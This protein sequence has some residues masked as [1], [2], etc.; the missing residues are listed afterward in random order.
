MDHQDNISIPETNLSWNLYGAG[1]DNL[2][3]LGKPEIAPVAQPDS[4]QLLVRVDCVGICYSD[5]KLLQQGENHPKIKSR[6]L[7]DCP[8]SPGHEV[9]FTVILVGDSL[10]DKFRAG[11]RYVVQPEIV[12]HNKK[13]TYGFSFPGGLTQYQ[14]IGSELLSTDDGVSILKIDDSLG[15]AEACLLEPWGSVLST[16][17]NTRRLEPKPGGNMWIIG[18]PDIEIERD[19]SKYLDHPEFILISDLPSRLE[20]S[21]LVANKNVHKQNGISVSQYK[22]IVEKQDPPL[23]FDDIVI[24]DPQSAEQIEI[25]ISMINPGGLINLI[26]NKPLDR[27]IKLDPQRIHYDFISIIGN[28]SSDLAESYGTD[29]NRSSLSPKGTA[30]FYGAG[31]AMGQIHVENAIAALDGPEKIVVIDINQERLD[32]LEQRFARLAQQQNKSLHTVNPLS[33]LKDLTEHI[34]ELI[35]QEY[36]NDVV[37]LVPDTAV[38]KKA[39]SLLGEDSLL[40]LFAG[41]PA[42]ASFPID[43]SNVYLGNLQITGSSGL[44][45]RHII[46]AYELAISGKIN[47]AASVVAVGGMGAALEAIQAVEEGRYPGK[48]VIYPHL[49][50]LPL[51]RV[52]DLSIQYPEMSKVVDERMIWSKEAEEI[53]LES[54]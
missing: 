38:F 25:L 10:K 21:I 39:A 7:S 42:G 50:D 28:L 14:L 54:Q 24:I 46:A 34:K 6:N 3:K 53:L 16:Y 48:I 43:I 36:A 41:T 23:K 26:G 45:F 27:P 18:N 52:K 40:N 31:G 37:V 2:G 20:E 1:Y 17:E 5:V 22:I 13:L 35:D 4:E 29:R 9:S 12:Q 44:S 51:T 47:I 30:V 49:L 19:F 33:S 15:Y 8:I 32:Y 11:E